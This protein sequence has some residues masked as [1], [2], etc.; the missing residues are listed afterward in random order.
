MVFFGIS[1]GILILAQCAYSMAFSLRFETIHH[2][3]WF[4]AVIAFCCLLPFGS[5][6]AFFMYLASGDAEDEANCKCIKKFIAKIGLSTDRPDLFHIDPSDGEL[7]K[8]IKRKMDKHLGFVIEAAIEALPQSLLQIIAIVYYQEA[9]YISIISIFLSM[10]SVT[11]KSLVLSQ[12][13]DKVTFIWTWLCI[14]TDFFGIFFTL[15]WV[16]YSNDN[17]DGDFLGYFNIFGEIWFWK[18]SVSVLFPVA[19]PTV[20]FFGF[21]YCFTF[22]YVIYYEDQRTT[23]MILACLW[24]IFGTFTSIMRVVSFLC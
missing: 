21:G 13:M 12:G 23:S 19:V 4:E 3:D 20:F 24:L 15:S 9:N 7:I 22:V 14:V 1:L 5:L 6:I 16:F 17:I 10:F 18:F 2:W 11:S 8:W